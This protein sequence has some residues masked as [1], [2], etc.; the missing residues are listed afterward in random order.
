MRSN[1]MEL[2]TIIRNGM[3]RMTDVARRHQ[4][5]ALTIAALLAAAGSAQFLRGQLVPS[6]TS[7]VA[8]SSSSRPEDLRVCDN[9]VTIFK[10]DRTL[11][12]AKKRVKER[13]SGIVDEREKFFRTPSEWKCG[14]NEKPSFPKLDQ[15]ADDLPGWHY[16]YTPSGRL[17]SPLVLKKPVTFDA[18]SAIAN[19]LQREYECTLTKFQDN[20]L[21]EVSMN[22][23]VSEPTKFCCQSQGGEQSCAEK[24]PETVC[25]GAETDDSYCDNQCLI[26]IYT[27]DLTKRPEVYHAEQLVERQR[28]R[29]A[30]ER[31]LQTLRS[32]EMNYVVARQL[33]CYQ[34]ASLDLKNELNLLADTTS[35]IPKIWNAVTSIHDRKE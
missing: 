30:L 28:S 20:T 12:K 31:T 11:E 23:D 18:F 14:P 22:E 2:F 5:L 4:L 6:G 24:T 33:M 17:D 9:S 15:L 25:T 21:G 29:L 1:A 34:R 16:Q 10:D 19:E 26:H 35:C 3:T 32:F 13:M 8:G 7:G 27:T